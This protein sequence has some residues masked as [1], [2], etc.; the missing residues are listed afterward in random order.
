MHVLT[1][2]SKKVPSNENVLSWTDQGT[3]LTFSSFHSLYVS[4]SIEVNSVTTE[5]D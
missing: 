5:T 1:E 3:E 2:D 4:E